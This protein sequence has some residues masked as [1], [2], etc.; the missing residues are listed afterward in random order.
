MSD[1]QDESSKTEEPTAKKLRDAREK[2]Q[3]AKSQEVG[4]WFSIFG[5]LLVI[6]LLAP[7]AATQLAS[8]LGAFLT[9]LHEV[10]TD[11]GYLIEMMARATWQLVLILALPLMILVV[12]AILGNL[13]QI[14]FLASAESIK[15]E[16]SKISPIAGF[17][18]LFSAKAL[19]EFAKGLFKIVII[20]A[21]GGLILWPETQLAEDIVGMDTATVLAEMWRIAIKLF[22]AVLVVLAMIAGLDFL[23]QRYEH[24]RKLRMTMQEVRDEFKQ[25]EGDPKIKGRIRQIRAERARTRMMQSVPQ[26]DVVVTNPT[27]YAIALKYDPNAMAAPVCVAKG[28]DLVAHRIRDVAGEHKVPIVENPPLARALFATVEIDQEVPVEHYQAVAEIISYVFKLQRRSMPQPAA[29]A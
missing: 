18:R 6:G 24:T 2:G 27:H 9:S 13:V 10:P 8:M 25:L 14:G 4:Y 23:Y 20:G 28:A 29:D 26:A 16:L 7:T 3:V 12:L 21:I 19:V 15:P 5:G 11:S 17:K 22:L 1:D